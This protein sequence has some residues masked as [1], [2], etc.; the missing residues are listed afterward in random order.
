ML[1]SF[2]QSFLKFHLLLTT[3]YSTLVVCTCSL[4]SPVTLFITELGLQY[5]LGV[6]S[7]KLIYCSLGVSMWRCTTT[8]VTVFNVCVFLL[9]L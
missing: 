4:Y 7:T 5:R 9:T 1:F 8:S 2:F 6:R 3:A